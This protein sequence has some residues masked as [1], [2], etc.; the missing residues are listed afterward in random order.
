MTSMRMY[1]NPVLSGFYPDPSVCRVG[2]DY[3]L[4]CS[5]F[6][7][8][9]GVPIFHS[10]DLVHW[11]QIGNVLD[12]PGQLCIP[13]DVPASHGIYAPTLRHHDG[14]F[15]DDHHQRV[16]R[17][18]LHRPADGTWWMV[19]LGT[20]PRGQSPEFHVI[21]RETFLTPVHGS[22]DGRSLGRCASA[23]SPPP[24]G[25]R[26]RDPRTATTSTPKR[27]H[28]NGLAKEPA[29]ALVL[30]QHPAGVADPAR[31]RHHSQP[32]WRRV[33]RPSP[34]VPRVAGDHP[35]RPGRDPGRLVGTPRLGA[36]LRH[37]GTRGARQRQPASGE[38]RRQCSAARGR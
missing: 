26:Y 8:F 27:W 7:Y 6:E 25:I 14:R 16:P 1:D 38:V 23:N 19:L 5:S 17:R 34:N 15:S 28:P 22:T 11:Q 4:V 37:R 24:P 35:N 10:R 2:H 31:H 30:P 33:H 21:G 36:P 12:R 3:Y 18:H 20:R 32:A 13:D 29:G 9:P